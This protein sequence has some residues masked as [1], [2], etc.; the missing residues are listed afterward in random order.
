MEIDFRI[1]KDSLK[2][3]NHICNALLIAEDNKNI[4]KKY[5]NY[6]DKKQLP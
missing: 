3:H 6:L 1:N 4:L 2:E 5:T